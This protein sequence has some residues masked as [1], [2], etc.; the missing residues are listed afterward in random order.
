M[1]RALL[2]TAGLPASYWCYAT[3]TA[4]YIKNRTPTAANEGMK[5]P[6]EL[7]I[8]YPP[9]V[10][11]IRTFGCKAHINQRKETIGKINSRTQIGILLGYDP[12]TKDGYLVYLPHTRQLVL[13]RDVL[14]DEAILPGQEKKPRA[15]PAIDLIYSQR[16]EAS[17]SEPLPAIEDIHDDNNE[18]HHYQETNDAHNDMKVIE[19]G[20]GQEK[21]EDTDKQQTRT[22]RTKDERRIFGRIYEDHFFDHPDLLFVNED[23]EMTEDPSLL[24]LF[25]PTILK[26]YT[27]AMKS[28]AAD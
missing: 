23:D 1:A 7:F 24:Q 10:G 13:S 26:T 22:T 20:N 21:E 8:G 2:F 18:P 27:Q 19:E 14:F 11:H 6:H 28:T 12:A 25:Q 17:V 5:T 16:P 4:T 15:P 9:D 3:A